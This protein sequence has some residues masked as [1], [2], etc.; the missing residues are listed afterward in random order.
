MTFSTPADRLEISKSRYTPTWKSPPSRDNGG[1]LSHVRGMATARSRKRKHAGCYTQGDLHS[2]VRKIRRGARLRP[3]CLAAGLNPEMVKRYIVDDAIWK[4]RID[5]AL[6]C[7]IMVAEQ[8]LFKSATK[9]DQYGRL[10]E[11]ATMHYL[12]NAAPKEWKHRREDVI[13]ASSDRAPVRSA[14]DLAPDARK[15]L[16]EDAKDVLLKRDRDAI[17]EKLH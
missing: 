6:G 1:G 4:K 15:Q 11:R 8:A 10:N 3:A 14:S 16:Q 12:T 5:K 2:L 13:A 17:A 7:N 9:P